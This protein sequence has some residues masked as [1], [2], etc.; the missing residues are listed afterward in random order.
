MKLIHGDCLEVLKTIPD[1][2]IDFILT[3][4]PYGTTEC[5]WDQ[6]IPFEAMWVELK[7]I[8]KPSKVI[9]LFGSEP[10]SSSLRIS[11]LPQFRYDWV[12]EKPSGA[13][14]LNAKYQP[15]KVHEIISIFCESPSVFV[16]NKESSFFIPQLTEGVPYSQKSG[17]QRTDSI[18]NKSTMTHVITN[19]SGTRN[20]RSII[21]FNRDKDKLH[22]TQKPVELLEYFIKSYTN[23][24]ET[25]LD[26]TMGSGSTGVACLNTNRQFIGIEKDEK[27]FNIAKERL[28]DIIKS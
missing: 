3:D 4:L 28:N 9:A 10:F 23:E 21:K 18:M 8:I 7:R 11:N 1:K 16:K 12:W 22:P 6:I 25:V 17:S 14:F 26:F 5:S 20:P 15:L 19:N 27:Y 13:N 24:G 2:S